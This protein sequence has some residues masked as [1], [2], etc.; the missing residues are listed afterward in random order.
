L[1]TGVQ[2]VLLLR[3][4]LVVVSSVALLVEKSSATNQSQA[5]PAGAGLQYGSITGRVM[6][7]DGPLPYAGVVVSPVGSGARRN[8]SRSV[9]ADAD[10]NFK[11]DGLRSIAWRVTASAPGYVSDT[12]LNQGTDSIYHRIGDSV[13]I[14]MIKGGVITGRVL[15]SLGGPLIAVRVNAQMVR[16]AL[17]NAVL[18]AGSAEDYQTDDRGIYRIF[19]LR[20]GAYVVVAGSSSGF[21]NP[22]PGF[23]PGPYDGDV[24][25]YHPS[26]TRDAAAEVL[27][28]SGVESGGIDI[29]YRSEKGHAISGTISGSVS[30]NSRPGGFISVTLAHHA[31]GT[32][33]NRA[34][35]VR[36]GPGFLNNNSGNNAFAIYGVPDGDYEVTA[37]RNSPDGDDAAS[38]PRRVTV[39][40][41]DLTGIE[42]LL[43]PLASIYGRLQL[44]SANGCPGNRKLSFEEQV[45]TLRAEKVNEQRSPGNLPRPSVPDREG[46]VAFRELNAGHYRLVPQLFD[47]KWFIRSIT[48]PAAP[49]NSSRTATKT[50][51]KPSSIDVGRHGL[52]LKS[53]ERVTSMTITIVEGA[54]A[55]KGK[56]KAAEGEKMPSL[57]VV[58][59]IPIE[60]QKADD[61]LRY[62]ETKINGDNE[63]NLTNLE[64]GKYWII[65]HPALKDDDKPKA[66]TVAERVKLRKEAETL[67]NMIDLQ[68]CQQIGSYELVYRNTAVN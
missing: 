56:V 10:G 62:A 12:P 25:V 31:T 46:G 17:G 32:V 20:A 49:T 58:H 52:S 2:S 65:A 42:L 13:T 57:L 50:A 14:R 7:D 36:R 63:F 53:G 22:R 21:Q 28:N 8:P 27:V 61:V 3:I 47:A 5:D 29:Q 55:V 45:F 59:L 9:T 48:V 26:S 40:G 34:L 43:K 39:A 37:Y 33:F 41:R 44:E 64:P 1:R 35:V 23:R 4:L 30:E 18:G 15:N 38:L 67:N 11:V 51:V 60:R 6:G 66:W 68:P 16:D 54:A 24:P 19:G